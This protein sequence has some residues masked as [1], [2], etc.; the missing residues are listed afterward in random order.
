[1]WGQKLIDAVTSRDTDAVNAA[2]TAAGTAADGKVAAALTAA[3]TDAQTKATT[4]LNSAKSYVD[5]KVGASTL[6]LGPQDPVPANTPAGTV[7]FR[8]T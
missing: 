4:A 3:G 2:V 6:V 8:T 5:G 1:V 7:I